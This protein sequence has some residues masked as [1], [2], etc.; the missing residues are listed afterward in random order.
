MSNIQMIQSSRF[1]NL[2]NE[3]FHE[4]KSYLTANDL[5]LAFFGL[6]TRFNELLGS[7][8]NLHFE[9][10][11]A[12]DDQRTATKFFGSSIISASV[13]HDS[14]ATS[15]SSTF[16]H[17]RSLTLQRAIR[18]TSTTFSTIE[19][20]TLDLSN[21]RL[22]HAACLCQWLFSDRGQ[23]L[24][25]F[26]LIHRKR[27]AVGHWKPLID[28][29][30]GQS[31]TLKLFIY[32][33]QPTVEWNAFVHFLSK[34]PNLERLIVKKL[35]TRN[36]WAQC[37]LAETLKKNVPNLN[38][39]SVRLTFLNHNTLTISNDDDDRR[40]HPLFTHV[41]SMKQRKLSGFNSTVII[42]S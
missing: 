22:K 21:M 26:H 24:R 1:E 15:I 40:L 12:V 25:V 32:D 20:V 7:L 42:S 2:P 33:V 9:I 18:L 10:R 19:R 29:I 16:S 36:R 34:M 31:S 6:N 39:L 37:N 13:R 23:S 30:R 14:H 35:N 8:S 4:L 41:I 38:F 11:S 5:Y 28:S 17:L 27:R 3:I